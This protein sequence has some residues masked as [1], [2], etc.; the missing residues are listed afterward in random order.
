VFVYENITFVGLDAHAR[1][2]NVAVVLPRSHV[3]DEQWQAAHEGRSLRRLVK[4]LKAMAPG[5]IWAVYKAGPCVY[6]LQ[7]TLDG[8]GMCC[9]VVAPSL[10]PVTPGERVKTD[11]RDARGRATLFKGGCLRSSILRMKAKKR[12]SR[13]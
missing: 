7:R 8:L 3:I 10:I 9:Q 12:C 1:D 2:I 5:E 13:I 4:K 11:R 6:A